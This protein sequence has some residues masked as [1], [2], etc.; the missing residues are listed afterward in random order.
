MFPLNLQ[1][2]LNLQV[3]YLI[4][5][6]LTHM[7]FIRNSTF[8]IGICPDMSVCTLTGLYAM[9]GSAEARDLLKLMKN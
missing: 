1:I 6:C 3:S 4:N 8:L 7:Y 9:V 5:S 2:P